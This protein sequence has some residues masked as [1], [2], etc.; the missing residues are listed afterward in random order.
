[1]IRAGIGYD[2]HP[3]NKGR[4]L[5][6]GG[7]EIPFDLGLTGHSDADVLLH[8]ICD[9]LLGAAGEGDIGRHFPNTDPLYKDISSLELLKRCVKII[10]EKG[11]SIVNI[12]SVI[13]AEAPKFAPYV[14]KMI[15]K[16]SDAAEISKTAI[17]IKATTNEKMGFIGKGEGI[18][19]Y[20]V[21]ILQKITA[22]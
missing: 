20:S 2:V 5:F 16:I 14:D 6:V 18:A 8:S 13:I 3:F 4:K 12:D 10:G 15:D 7:I 19:A 17:N 21:C 11:Y 1:M 9:A 22:L